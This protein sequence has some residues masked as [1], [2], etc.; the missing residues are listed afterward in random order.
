MEC[1]SPPTGSSAAREMWEGGMDASHPEGRHGHLQELFWTEERRRKHLW[2][3]NVTEDSQHSTGV[4]PEGCYPFSSWKLHNYSVSYCV[5]LA[6]CYIA[7]DFLCCPVFQSW[8]C[9]L[10]SGKGWPAKA[11]IICFKIEKCGNFIPCGSF[12]TTH[13]P[14]S[15]CSEWQQPEAIH[16]GGISA[17]NNHNYMK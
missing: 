16:K 2:S 5:I 3:R 14:A 12:L 8:A 10:L 9:H 17:C 4:Q 11:W 7:G 13:P 6:W 15:R 1:G